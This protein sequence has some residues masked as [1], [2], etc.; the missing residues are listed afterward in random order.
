MYHDFG[1][2]LESSSCTCLPSLWV[3]ATACSSAFFAWTMSPQFKTPPRTWRE[4][5]GSGGNGPWLSRE[6]GVTVDFLWPGQKL[7]LVSFLCARGR[8][9]G[10][11]GR[12]SIIWLNSTR[13]GPVPLQWDR[14]PPT[15]SLRKCGISECASPW[16][17]T[18]LARRW[19]VRRRMRPSVRK[20]LKKP[21]FSS[22][23][24]HYF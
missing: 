5:K 3:I 9:G 13:L 21:V 6:P 18:E 19:W 22:C 20:W 7:W 8:Q 24:R 16:N 2:M 15:V 12:G 14:H 1:G 10:G 17:L 23:V 11:S 4:A